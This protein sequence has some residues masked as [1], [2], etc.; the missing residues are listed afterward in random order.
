MLTSD[1]LDILMDPLMQ[2]Y[3]RFMQ[4][5]LNDIA[6]RLSKMPMTNAAAWQM[7]R[8]IQS[9]ETYDAALDELAKL[10]GKSDVELRQLFQKAG[11]R[12]VAFDDAVYKTAGLKPLPLNLS[13]AM[14]QTLAAGLQKTQGIVRNLTMSTALSA[15]N[16]FLD[17][18]DLA[19]MQVSSGAFDYVTAIKH[20]VQDIV[21]KG[22]PVI[23]YANGHTDQVD[24][25]VRRAVLTGVSQTTGQLQLDRAREMGTDLVAV[26]AHLGARNKGEGPMNHESW[27]GKIYSVSGGSKEYGNFV[28]I[29]GFGTGEG[30]LGWNCRHSFYPWIEGVS[31]PPPDPAQYEGRIVKYNGEE[32]TFYEA[33]Q[34]QRYIERQIRYWKRRAGA[35]EAAGQNNTEERLKIGAW[36]KEMRS[37]LGQMNAQ[38]APGVEW[39]RQPEREQVVIPPPVENVD[40]DLRLA[41]EGRLFSV[42]SNNDDVVLSKPIDYSIKYGNDVLR[43]DQVIFSQKEKTYITHGHPDD[44][45]WFSENQDLV[46]KAISNP[47]FVDTFPSVH[48]KTTYNIA[49]LLYIGEKDLPFLNVVLNFRKDKPAKIWTMFRVSKNYVYELSGDK[50]S[51]WKNP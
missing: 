30:L 12:S 26:S 14:A 47:L 40:R 37:F 8:L 31:N 15:Q 21:D 24:V 19:Y 5:A 33:T 39:Y 45:R 38:Q 50:K 6:W 41:Q 20:A 43:A 23:R 46:L 44:S 17:A 22:L 48:N 35:L 49:H 13:P 4:S 11:V 3:E 1:Q 2:L 10:T 25:A 32:M 34:K 9:G 16:S 18:A 51:R 29:T 36:Q 28:E 27:Q 7:Q 42:E